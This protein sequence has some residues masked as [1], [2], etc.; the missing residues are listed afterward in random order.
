VTSLPVRVREL[1]SVLAER[2][3]L[4]FETAHFGTGAPWRHGC[5]GLAVRT[6]LRGPLR[7][8]CRRHDVERN[9]EGLTFGG[10]S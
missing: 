4:P 10:K 7:D 9:G 8:T 6:R 3:M 2:V 1:E 5:S